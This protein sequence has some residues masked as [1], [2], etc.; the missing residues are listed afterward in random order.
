MRLGDG[1]VVDREA[2]VVATRMVAR[3]SFLAD[4]G[5]R[6]TKHPSGLGEHIAA[7]PTGRTDLPGVWAAG[8]VPTWPPRSG[9][10]AAGAFAAAQINADLVAEETRQAV[11]AYRHASSAAS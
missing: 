8:N 2:V 6:P 5:L 3:A 10:L 4:L 9:L 11:E 7:D 1:T